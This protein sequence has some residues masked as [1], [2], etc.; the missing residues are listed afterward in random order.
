VQ[1]LL[2]RCSLSSVRT[3]RP[4]L[5]S[6][7]RQILRPAC[8]ILAHPP[9]GAGILPVKI[10]LK[11]GAQRHRASILALAQRCVG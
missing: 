8:S 3:F 9:H 10:T 7:P 6:P 5:L 11:A 4:S 1:D 2:G